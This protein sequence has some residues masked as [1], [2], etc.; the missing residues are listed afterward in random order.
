[1]LS[2][3]NNIHGVHA[4]LVK[5]CRYVIMHIGSFQLKNHLNLLLKKQ[6]H[7]IYVDAL[8]HKHHPFAIIV[9]TVNQYNG[10]RNRT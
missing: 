9:I 7:Y 3:E 5:T 4:D 8:K 10:Y 6:L 2:K 1:M